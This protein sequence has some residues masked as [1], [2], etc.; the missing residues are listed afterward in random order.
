M[1]FSMQAHNSQ[2]LPTQINLIALNYGQ[3]DSNILS[4]VH[5]HGHFNLKFLVDQIFLFH[6]QT[7]HECPFS[8]PLTFKQANIEQSLWLRWMH[9]ELDFCSDQYF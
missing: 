2:F 5:T 7:K 3:G 6:F 1:A 8:P 4:A 9:Q